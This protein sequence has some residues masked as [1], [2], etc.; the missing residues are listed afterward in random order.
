MFR[1]ELTHEYFCVFSETLRKYPPVPNLIRLA[2]NDYKIP[3]TEIVIE[4]GTLVWIPAYA[5]HHDPEN[6]PEP[7]KF[8]PERFTAEQSAG[9][10]STKWLP[11][12]EGPRNCVGLRFGMMQT[13]IGLSTLLDSFDISACAKTTVTLKFVPKNFI[14]TPDE[15]IYLKFKN[16]KI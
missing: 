6:Y 8:R 9:R 10:E 11:F 14:L 1:F 16:L 4:K 12:G 2:Q 13:R 15:G 7:E 3:D 5:I